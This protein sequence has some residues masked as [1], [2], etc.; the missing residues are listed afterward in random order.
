MMGMWGRSPVSQSPI[1]MQKSRLGQETLVEMHGFTKAGSMAVVPNTGHIPGRQGIEVV[2]RSTFVFTVESERITRLRM[3]QE[4]AD[5]LE[6]AG[7]SEY[8]MSQENV[9]TVRDAF[10]AY[11]RGDLDAFLGS[12]TRTSGSPRS[13]SKESIAARSSRRSVLVALR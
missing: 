9:R 8:A 7:L 4:R 10:V 5:A 1:A 12:A 13:I 11:N 3:F 2:A 6:A